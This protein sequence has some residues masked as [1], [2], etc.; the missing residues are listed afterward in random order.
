MKVITR[1]LERGAK[2]APQR[3]FLPHSFLYYSLIDGLNRG[4]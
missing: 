4:G 2:D 1:T 3:R